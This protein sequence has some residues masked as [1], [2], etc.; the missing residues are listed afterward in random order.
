M[1]GTASAELGTHKG[2]WVRG[3][4]SARRLFCFILFVLFCLAAPAAYGSSRAR[5]QTRATA[6]TPAS[7]VTP[8]DAEGFSLQP[9]GL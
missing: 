6:A 8:P 4:L 5:D 2:E 3:G 1:A 7:V 9:E